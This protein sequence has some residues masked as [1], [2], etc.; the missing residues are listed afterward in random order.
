[1]AD[2]KH[3]EELF[4]EAFEQ[5]QPNVDP[6]VWT[7]LEGKL[8]QLSNVGGA[9]SA[10]G[11]S[12]GIGAG[13]GMLKTVLIAAGLGIAAITTAVVLLSDREAEDKNAEDSSSNV[14]TQQLTPDVDKVESNEAMNPVD[15]SS[16]MDSQ[17]AINPKTL[18][19]AKASLE[20]K[21]DGNASLPPMSWADSWLTSPGKTYYHDPQKAQTAADTTK[22]KSMVAVDEKD[23]I[24]PHAKQEIKLEVVQLQKTYFTGREYSFVAKGSFSKVEWH[25]GDGTRNAGTN[26]KHA[27]NER[28]ELSLEVAA[29][30]AAGEKVEQRY[31]LVVE[32][33]PFI[34]V[35]NIFTPN[36]DGVNDYFVLDEYR[37][38]KSFNMTVMTLGG[39]IIFSSE[40]PEEGWNGEIQGQPAP[41]G[42]YM[43]TVQAIGEDNVAL[44][45]VR[46]VITLQRS[47]R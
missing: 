25:F 37:L 45:M 29:Y 24:V 26:V 35:P 21:A 34:T 44:P 39:D 28:G 15:P 6:N 2:G 9:S 5:Y 14:V 12:G 8:D 17:T 43:V 1:M 19:Q 3:I 47:R 16:Q 33:G 46:K 23:P 20:P 18:S 30:N 10:G 36:G 27:F 32:E 4:K 13:A 42:Q 11:A 31:T 40:N 7:G 38:I 22:P 41:E